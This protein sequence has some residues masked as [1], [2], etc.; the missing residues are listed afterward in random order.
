M[1]SYN[2]YYSITVKEENSIENVKVKNHS[3]KPLDARCMFV[4]C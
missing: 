3:G 1:F 2:V 4:R